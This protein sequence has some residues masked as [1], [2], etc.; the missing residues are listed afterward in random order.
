MKSFFYR[1]KSTNNKIGCSTS[2]LAT[3]F[4]DVWERI[5]KRHNIKIIT[6]Y[7]DKD[8]LLAGCVFRKYYAIDGKRIDV[9]IAPPFLREVV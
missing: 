8:S 6:E 3:D 1:I 9:E 4:N 5:Q 7:Y 2:I